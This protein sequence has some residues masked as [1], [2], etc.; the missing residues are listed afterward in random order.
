MSITK[1]KFARTAIMLQL[2]RDDSNLYS[3]LSACI[4]Q[5]SN[6]E[7][8]VKKFLKVNLHGSKFIELRK[9]ALAAEKDVL[10]AS[11]MGETFRDERS[12][13]ITPRC[14]ADLSLKILNIKKGEKV[15][16]L[17][18]GTGCFVETAYEHNQESEF[19]GVE[20]N[21]DALAIAKIKS[22]FSGSNIKYYKCDVFS[23]DTNI[24]YDKVF[25][26]PPFSSS[27]DDIDF[28][29]QEIRIMKRGG[30]GI[31]VCT[32]LFLESVSKKY[33]EARERLLL[34]KRIKA[35]IQLPPHLLPSTAAEVSLIILGENCK[36]IRLIDASDF[37]TRKSHHYPEL[38]IDSIELILKGLEN[39]SANSVMVS[40]DDAKC[41]NFSLLPQRY[42]QEEIELTAP[43]SLSSVCERITRGAMLKTTDIKETN[44]ETN[45]YYLNLGNINEGYIDN[46]LTKIENISLKHSKYCVQNRDVVLTF[47]SS[48][49]KAAVVSVSE[50]QRILA[51]SNVYVITVDKGKI[52]PTYLVA[53][54]NSDKGRE[55]LRRNT[56]GS[57]VRLLPKKSLEAI[58]IPLLNKEEQLSIAEKYDQ[59][60]SK[61]KDSF[62]EI[63]AIKNKL[64]DLF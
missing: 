55:T 7:D 12:L 35:V 22:H 61:I 44:E 53:F 28:L 11:L 18:S 23:C 34:Q 17:C 31:A 59:G 4:G 8:C 45:Y 38:T 2:L 47:S 51:S 15:V 41:K 1:K 56:S 40:I 16:D 57:A 25:M 64:A 21:E 32:R 10:F 30:T 26:H 46:G 3:S 19:Y 13:C 60:I 58:Q 49:P 14:I 63:K 27:N 33:A 9:T 24:K 5:I 36:Q 50:N 39:E 42:F 52:S 29:D 43:T 54:L 48:L 20:I 37:A 62:V 6:G